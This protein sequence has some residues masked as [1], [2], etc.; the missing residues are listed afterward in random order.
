M[1]G[2]TRGGKSHIILAMTND[3][4]YEQIGPGVFVKMRNKVIQGEVDSQ[5][6]SKASPPAANQEKPRAVGGSTYHPDYENFCYCSWCP[7]LGAV[8]LLETP[9]HKTA[10]CPSPEEY[11]D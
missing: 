9:H 5:D 6:T 1:I 4:R 8:P 7:A 3:P 10:A 11:R 2:G